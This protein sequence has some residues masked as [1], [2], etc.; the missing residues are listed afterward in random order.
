LADLVNTLSCGGSKEK[1]KN[2]LL[3]IYY[4]PKVSE[5]LDESKNTD[6]EKSWLEKQMLRHITI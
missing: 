3:G 4:V 5:M 2:V 1:Y 6:A